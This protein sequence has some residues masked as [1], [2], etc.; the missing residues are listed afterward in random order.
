MTELFDASSELVETPIL[1]YAAV[2]KTSFDTTSSRFTRTSPCCT[3]LVN[4]DNITDHDLAALTS[5]AGWVTELTVID[6]VR[7][8][9]TCPLDNG[10]LL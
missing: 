2:E 1:E 6:P 10:R 7:L 4:I 3:P 9:E 5:K 8:S